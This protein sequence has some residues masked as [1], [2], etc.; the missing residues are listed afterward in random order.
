M[1]SEPVKQFKRTQ[2]NSYSSAFQQLKNGF[3][4]FAAKFVSEYDSRLQYTRFWYYWHPIHAKDV[5]SLTKTF[6]TEISDD[7]HKIE[8][9]H[10]QEN[11][12][13]KEAFRSK[14][15]RNERSFDIFKTYILL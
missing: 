10:L 15:T 12:K 3:K 7:L 9:E 13:A 5:F 14:N 8:T 4:F 11:V 2:L 1:D 6:L